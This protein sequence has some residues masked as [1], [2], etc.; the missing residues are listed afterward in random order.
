MVGIN[1]NNY[2]SQV[3]STFGNGSN[4]YQN[5]TYQQ[6]QT[7]NPFEGGDKYSVDNTSQ[8][9]DQAM[10]RLTGKNVFTNQ[11]T[12]NPQMTTQ[13][14]SSPQLPAGVTQSDL[15]WAMALEQK[16]QQGYTPTQQET[17][18]YQSIAAK[19]SAA[20]TSPT[21]N[22]QTQQNNQTTPNPQAIGVTQEEL[23][24]AMAI[25]NAVK[26][27]YTPNAQEA[28]AYQ[29]IANKMAAAKNQNQQF[30]TQNTQQTNQ[31]PTGVSQ[32]EVEWASA[33]ESKVKQGYKPTN[34]E[35]FAYNNILNKV[36]AAKQQTT[37]S[38]TQ[39]PAG[40]SQQEIQW[41]LELENKVK[42]GY[43]PT[44]QET[45]T[46]Q[47][48]SQKL[49]AGQTQ[50]TQQNPTTQ[51]QQL[52]AG[53][54]QQELDWA[55]Q[56]ENKV[57]GGYTPTAQ[58]TQAYQALAQKLSNAPAQS[59][60]ANQ[61][62]Q[63]TNQLPAGV[64]Q[65]EIDWALQLENK[66]KG[67]YTPNAQETQAYQALAQKISAANSQKSGNTQ[68]PQVTQQEID[69][70]L[71]LE[72]KVKGGYNPTPDE[73]ATYQN[74]A[75]K[76]QVQQQAGNTQQGGKDWQ[77]WSQPFSVPRNLFQT[78]PNIIQV[79]TTLR[80]SSPSL[81]TYTVA[82]T[83]PNLVNVP[84]TLPMNNNRPV[85]NNSN[86]QAPSKSEIDWALALEDKVKKNGYTPNESELYQYK[87]IADRLAA[88][89]GKTSPVQNQGN[90]N[91]TQQNPQNGQKTSIGQRLS[92]AWS[93]LTK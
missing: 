89:Q 34:E 38:N 84:K 31:L 36:N 49:A 47:A 57:K 73:T 60:Q 76:I 23:N 35:T 45:Q 62:T 93:A 12:Q 64:T 14:T 3:P 71:Q 16:V 72:N 20:A 21:A 9:F 77:A 22:M 75:H 6:T 39:L 51:T 28:Q 32:Q 50:T 24:W 61:N 52:P 92:N 5:T 58:E 90:A 37:Q 15:N 18:V 7:P 66:V 54:T 13:N 78:T 44:A 67:G 41:A 8:A 56:L 30:T 80:S 2:T 53:V 10:A 86:S 26:G 68:V 33:F 40:V 25:E 11:T 48:L 46:Y 17:Q 63:Q 91:Q 29:N 88:S 74:I 87:N 19:L 85:S 42:G 55:L 43:T 83:G 27:G 82:N 59:T 69:W 70:A 1:N 65:Q 81:P 4:N 79:P